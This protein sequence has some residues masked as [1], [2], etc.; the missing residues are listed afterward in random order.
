MPSPM[1]KRLLLDGL[2]PISY[3]LRAEFSTPIAAPVGATIA[4]DVGGP[5]TVT[6][7]ESKISVDSSGNLIINGGKASPAAGDPGLW[8]PAVTRSN[9]LALICSV[10]VADITKALNIGFD[11]NVS[12]GLAVS[13]D[14]VQL[15]ASKYKTQASLTLFTPVNGVVYE[16]MAVALSPGALLLKRS[17]GTT[18]TV[19]G[20]NDV[21]T[22][23]PI[24]PSI[25]GNTAVITSAYLRLLSLAAFDSRFATRTGV[26]TSASASPSAGDTGVMQA[27]A[28]VEATWTPAAND[29]YELDVRRTDNDNR[30]IVRCDQAGSTIKLVERNAGGETERSSAAST[31][32]VGTAYRIIV[33][34]EGQSIQTT[35]GTGGKNNYA[36]S[37]FNLTAT[38]IKTSHAVTNLIAWPRTLTIA[39]I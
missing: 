22:T 13:G 6:D 30:W 31:W 4:C 23:T 12:G 16:L 26:S 19:L 32:T 14:G 28:W 1:L 33:V 9:G 21:N 27:D 11:A 29:V 34:C 36:L 18:W 2:A 5:L 7:T 17:S 37:S 35:V 10:A 24:Y 20:V 38:G 25:S 15:S 3:L 8:G 39:N